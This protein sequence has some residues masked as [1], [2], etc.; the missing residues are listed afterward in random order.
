MH[1]HAEKELE[2]ILQSDS[3]ARKEWRKYSKLKKDPRITSIGKVLR[4][5][6]LDE[7]PQ[8]FNVLIGS[9]SVVGPRPITEEEWQQYLVLKGHE[10]TTMENVVFFLSKQLDEGQVKVQKA[11]KIL[12]VKPGI[13]GLWQTSGRN[14][15][16]FKWR[17]KLEEKYIAKQS[18][19]FDLLLIIKTIPAVL[20]LKNAY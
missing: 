7:L 9:L 19:F 4:K 20:S 5:T 12:S 3:L 15:V 13:T 18:F 10:E 17:M 8:F 14:R 6:S 1:I 11:Q 16:P 2:K